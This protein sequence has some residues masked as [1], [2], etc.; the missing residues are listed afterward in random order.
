[1]PKNVSKNE[2]S[3]PKWALTAFD[4]PK[5][6]APIVITVNIYSYFSSFVIYPKTFS[7]CKEPS[8]CVKM[9][10]FFPVNWYKFWMLFFI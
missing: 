8:E 2:G 7:V 1:M 4:E 3:P 10:T 6:G 9:M 5:Y